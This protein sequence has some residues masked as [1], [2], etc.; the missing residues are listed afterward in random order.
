MAHPFTDEQLSQYTLACDLIG[1][2]VALKS[3][4]IHEEQSQ[5][6]PDEQRLAQLLE[7]QSRLV[8]ERE[9]IQIEDSETVK[10]VID[11]YRAESWAARA[12]GK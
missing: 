6:N 10:R 2:E 11:R 3:R 1:G 9:A 8:Q 7:E 4:D 5:P 12:A